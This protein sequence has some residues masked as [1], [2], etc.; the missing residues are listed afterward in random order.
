MVASF[1]DCKQNDDMHARQKHN[2][3]VPNDAVESVYG[4]VK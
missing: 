1:C 3:L 2:L 4:S